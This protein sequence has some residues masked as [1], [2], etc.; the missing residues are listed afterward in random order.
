[1]LDFIDERSRTEVS[2]EIRGEGRSCVQ[3]YIQVFDAFEICRKLAKLMHGTISLQSDK[4]IGSLFL[5]SVPC[6]RALYPAPPQPP[7]APLS[8]TPDATPLSS[9]SVAVPNAVLSADASNSF[10]ATASPLLP[11]FIPTTPPPIPTAT[12][13]PKK[14]LIVEVTFS[15]LILLLFAFFARPNIILLG[16]YSEP[17][18]AVA[19]TKNERYA[20]FLI[21]ENQDKFT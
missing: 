12:A 21:E 3:Q 9:L 17:G 4:G 18:R 7:S 5:L 19:T 14:I 13:P 20:S 11:S 2:C 10:E 15:T 1:M 16:Q 8:P 6:K